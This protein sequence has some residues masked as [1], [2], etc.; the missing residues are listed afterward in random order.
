MQLPQKED[1]EEAGKS[2]GLEEENLLEISRLKTGEAIVYQ[3]GWEES[4][5]SKISLFDYSKTQPWKF[6]KNTLATVNNDVELF[7][8]LYKGFTMHSNEIDKI[9][10]RE[11]VKKSH[12]S[13]AKKCSILT[14]LDS[15]LNNDSKFFANI[16]AELIGYALFFTLIKETCIENLNIKLHKDISILLP[17]QCIRNIETYKNM[18]MLG[19]CLK[20]KKNY[21]DKWLEETIK[22]KLL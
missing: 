17:N 11:M 6:E 2:V 9:A 16:F 1:R 8:I 21:Y 10:I 5:K 7:E 3:T 19:C 13:G 4:V 20:S 14:Y 18:Y 12:I 22:T 15:S